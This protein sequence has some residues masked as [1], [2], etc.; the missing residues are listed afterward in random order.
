M[1]PS[2]STRR[3]LNRRSRA[4]AASRLKV[5]RRFPKDDHK[6]FAK[7]RGSSS[8]NCFAGIEELNKTKLQRETSKLTDELKEITKTPTE[9][10]RNQLGNNNRQNNQNNNEMMGF[11]TT[12]KTVMATTTSK[13]TTAE[14]DLMER[15]INS[16]HK[17]TKHATAKINRNGALAA[18]MEKQKEPKWR[19]IWTCTLQVWSYSNCMLVS[20]I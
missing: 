13:I 7:L 15:T 9:F 12:A 1:I 3:F 20:L 16:A 6:V 8:E 19:T 2:H 17:T 5:N 18:G 4:K 11:A 10:S 14:R